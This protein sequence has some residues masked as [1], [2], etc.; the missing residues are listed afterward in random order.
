MFFKSGF[1]SITTVFPS[2]LFP[3]KKYNHPDRMR[4]MPCDLCGQA[5]VFSAVW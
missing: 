1:P 3:V 4:A 2:S 5:H